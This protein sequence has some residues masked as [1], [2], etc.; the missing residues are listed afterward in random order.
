MRHSNF[1]ITMRIFLQTRSACSLPDRVRSVLPLI[2]CLAGLVAVTATSAAETF[3]TPNFTVEA[4]S[5]H[6]AK[7]VAVA[8]EEHRFRFAADWL[9]IELEDWDAPCQITVEEAA[10]AGRGWTSYDV[11]PGRVGRF[12]IT[13]TGTLQQIQDY[14]LP[15]EVTHTVLARWM[16]QAPPRWAD[17][18]VALLSETESQ[19]A[20][21]RRLAAELVAARRVMP[22]KEMIALDQ[23]PQ[24]HREMIDFYLS[25][26]SLTE[27]LV[28]QGGRPRLLAFL[29]DVRKQGWEPALQ[30]H[31]AFSDAEVLEAAWH[32]WTLKAEGEPPI[33]I[34]TAT[35]AVEPPAPPEP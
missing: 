23:Y 3:A 19:K 9:G 30:H 26:F 33:E 27:F 31:Y 20:R 25:S 11:S 22:L 8:A 21:Q 13:L 24:D 2:V 28:A 35:A 18:G 1:L 14:I 7:S 32:S 15:H 29:G 4:S 17:E 5:L 16:G 12:H 6:V 34:A 10:S